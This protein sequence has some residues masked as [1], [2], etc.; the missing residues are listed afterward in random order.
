MGFVI[1]PFAFG[2]AGLGT[3]TYLGTVDS[4]TNNGSVSFASTSI[5]AAAADRVIVAVIHT[6]RP[7]TGIPRMVLTVAI[8]GN[9]MRL[10]DCFTIAG[11]STCTSVAMAS[12]AWPTGTTATISFTTDFANNAHTLHL[13][14]VRG[15][16]NPI[17]Y[18]VRGRAVNDASL[19]LHVPA[20]GPVIAACC[21]QEGTDGSVSWTGLSTVDDNAARAAGRVSCASMVGGSTDEL[22][23][24][25]SVSAAPNQDVLMALS[26]DSLAVPKFRPN[27]LPNFATNG[28][29]WDVADLSTITW[30]TL[31]AIA[32]LADKSGA[33]RNL[34]AGSAGVRSNR[35]QSSNIGTDRPAARFDGGNDI[36]DNIVSAYHPQSMCA[37]FYLNESASSHRTL[38]GVRKTTPAAYGADAMYFKVNEP[39][40]PIARHSAMNTLGVTTAGP[41]RTARKQLLTL[42]TAINDPT[43][44]RLGQN[45]THST[46]SGFVGTPHAGDRF[47]LGCG[48]FNG[49]Q[50]DFFIGDIAMFIGDTALW[51]QAQWEKVEGYAAHQVGLALAA[52]HP[53]ETTLP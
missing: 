51:T 49:N 29:F 38:F 15:V 22:D 46:G 47:V 21:S 4:T 11:A 20:Y 10:H 7:A 13:Y 45:G 31:P 41:S 30:G 6:R 17:P 25:I 34:G 40:T 3:V 14:A 44:M 48:Y 2:S 27:T 1:N 5:G 9:A 19:T 50:A 35:I 24:T 53:Y 37:V 8:D 43:A 23:R 39:T 12:K 28:A 18:H 33:G 32:G 42:Q 16:A 26:F 36:L 52:G